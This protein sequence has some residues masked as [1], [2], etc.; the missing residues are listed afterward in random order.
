[1][2]ATIGVK[3][4]AAAGWAIIAL[5]CAPTPPPSVQA[6]PAGGAR[7][8]SHASSTGS[9]AGAL[10][11]TPDAASSASPEG[12]SDAGGQVLALGMPRMPLA[13]GRSRVAV[14]LPARSFVSVGV[15]GP[16]DALLGFD[17][18]SGAELGDLHANGAVDEDGRL[19]RFL[20]LATPAEPSS[21][22]VLVELDA[23]GELA[24]VTVDPSA[25]TAP[26]PRE[27]K[28]GT[29]SARPL[30]GLPIP[31][32]PRDGYLLE[33]P[34]R[35]LFLRIDVVVALR[36]ALRQ[37]KTR[38]K[39]N[40]IAVGHASQWDGAAPGTDRGKAQHIGHR[41]GLEVDLGLPASDDSPSGTAR[42]CEG[43][44]VERE[45]LRCAPGTVRDLDAMRLAYLLGLLIDGPTPNGIYMPKN[46]PGPIA[47][48]DSILT[49]E[50]YIDEIRRAAK[51]LRR[52]RWIHDEGYAALMEDGLLRPSAWHV[53]HVHVRF[54]GEPAAPQ[55]T[56]TA[57]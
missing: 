5:S 57:P 2:V 4:L 49:D 24:R 38:F 36:T 56:P 11:A 34:Q 23:P 29:A 26:L 39:R 35:Y 30:I 18:A 3:R 42:R 53:D 10:A 37:A 41:S 19:P 50:A 25:L 54:A 31:V 21:L 13:A 44:L 46:R 27:L 7:A 32:D 52:K 14:E 20:S 55:L 15:L 22:M 28:L 1:M 12:P 43:V 6:S 33:A 17:T 51:E 48:V 47:L 9:D 16:G 8:G 45:V 40:A